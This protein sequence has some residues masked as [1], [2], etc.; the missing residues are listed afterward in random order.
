MREL[1]TDLIAIIII[2][3]MNLFKIDDLEPEVREYY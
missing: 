1:L 2:T 3:G